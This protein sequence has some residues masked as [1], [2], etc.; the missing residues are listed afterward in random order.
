MRLITSADDE[1][2]GLA[3]AAGKLGRATKLLGRLAEAC[4]AD[5]SDVDAAGRYALAQMAVLPSVGVEFA[6]HAR[7]TATVEAF[8]DVLALDPD[9]WLARYGRARLRALIPSSYGAYAVRASGDLE[10]ARDD[11]DHLLAGQAALPSRPYFISAHALATVLDQLGG[12]PPRAGRPALADALAAC[13]RTPV[14][15]VALGAVLCEP[16]A[17]LHAAATDAA[18]RQALGEV[19][20]AVYGGQPAVTAAVGR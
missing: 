15:L 10:S 4:R 14:R 20:R 2:Y 18:L 9:H 13:P 11:L 8:G 3:S 16:L 12:E 1:L 5:P 6:A 7:F 17:T 19:M